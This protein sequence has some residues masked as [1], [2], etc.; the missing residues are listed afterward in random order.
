MTKYRVYFFIAGILFITV[1]FLLNP[2][3]ESLKEDENEIISPE[4]EEE[5]EEEAEREKE[6]EKEPKKKTVK[7]EVLTAEQVIQMETGKK[8]DV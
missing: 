8:D 2:F 4:T 7:P 3:K 1:A 5:T 6:P